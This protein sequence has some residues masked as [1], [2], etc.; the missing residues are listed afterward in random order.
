MT[1]FAVLDATHYP[2]AVFRDSDNAYDYVRNHPDRDAL[3]VI[4]TRL[5]D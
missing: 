5:M 4:R 1:L 2:I 3:Y